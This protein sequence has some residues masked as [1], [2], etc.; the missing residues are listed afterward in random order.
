MP[1][2][3]PIYT[4]SIEW[5]S[6]PRKIRSEQRFDSCPCDR[7]FFERT[8]FEVDASVLAREDVRLYAQSVREKDPQLVPP[9]GLS[10]SSRLA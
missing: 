9:S 10:C 5:E 7:D 6:P 3:E 1:L 2:N 8:D 4:D